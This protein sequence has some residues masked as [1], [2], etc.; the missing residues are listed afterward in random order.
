MPEDYK[1]AWIIYAAA[2]TILLLA[3]WWFMRNWRWS[4]LRWALLLVLAAVL[5]VPARGTV[6]DSAAVPV[7]PLFVY[8]SLFEEE[9]ATPEVTASLV[10]SAG[11]VLGLMVLWGLLRLFLAHR[12]E[13]RR[14]FE[15]DPYFSDR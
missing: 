6:P 13:Q 3:G 14:R 9:G 1:L 12:R 10:F 2:T 4:W 8:Q 15:D 11:G 5:L 7:L